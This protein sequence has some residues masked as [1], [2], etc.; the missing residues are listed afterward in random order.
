MKIIVS[1]G[2]GIL[3]A[4]LIFG[5]LEHRPPPLPLTILLIPVY[6]L[7]LGIFG[8]GNANGE[9]FARFAL[10][11]ETGVILYC[12]LRLLGGKSRGVKNKEQGP[13]PK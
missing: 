10:G 8:H 4:W 2:L 9:I 3:F 5:Y 7:T 13:G 12:I 11:I 1:L 6:L